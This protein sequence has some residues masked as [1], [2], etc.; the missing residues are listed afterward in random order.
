MGHLSAAKSALARSRIE[1]LLLGAGLALAVAGLAGAAAP[2]KPMPAIAAPVKVERDLPP[3][4]ERWIEVQRPIEIFSLSAPNLGS[5]T[6]LYRGERS[7]T[8]EARRDTLRLGSLE[9]QGPFIAIS[10]HRRPTI[11]ASLSAMAR[12]LT[13]AATRLGR[14]G[15]PIKTK[16][17][18]MASA[19]LSAGGGRAC[20]AFDRFEASAQVAIEG[21]YCPAKG[22]GV[23]RRAAACLV[24]RLDL[25]GGKNDALLRR[26]FIEAETRR[27]FCGTGDLRTSGTNRVWIDSG[28]TIPVHRRGS[29]VR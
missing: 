25:L 19:E 14:A 18:D 5:E 12:R 28:T 3:A 22:E 6:L 15:M 10:V 8:D 4:G 1:R 11:V 13:G 21:V 20:L 29:F 2:E 16:F 27:D 23:D 26:Y 17:G 7:L 9:S 24:D